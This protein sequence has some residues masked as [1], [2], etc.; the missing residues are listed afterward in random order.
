MVLKK[1]LKAGRG[2][3]GKVG[4]QGELQVNRDI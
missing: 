2:P 3:Y 1:E 4:R